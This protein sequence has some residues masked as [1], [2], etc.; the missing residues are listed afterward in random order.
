M[1]NTVE[2]RLFDWLWYLCQPFSCSLSSEGYKYNVVPPLPAQLNLTPPPTLY[3]QLP[4]SASENYS[5]H[6]FSPSVSPE[7]GSTKPN[8][9]DINVWF[10]LKVCSSSSTGKE[11]AR[12]LMLFVIVQVWLIHFVK[13]SHLGDGPLSP[14]ETIN[15]LY[16]VMDYFHYPS[17]ANYLFIHKK[18]KS[19]IVCLSV[20]R[21]LLSPC[22]CYLA[23]SLYISQFT[24]NCTDSQ[25]WFVE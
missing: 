10:Q 2:C 18:K 16:S 3:P 6:R 13:F 15:C 9:A 23:C 20:C 11:G 8:R 1:I 17:F 24:L 25:K 5:F 14:V 12:L 22:I 7:I 21:W 4:M 19:Y